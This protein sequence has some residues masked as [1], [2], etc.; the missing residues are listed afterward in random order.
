MHSLCYNVAICINYKSNFIYKLKYY[1]P[2]PPPPP[3]K[4]IVILLSTTQ[5]FLKLIY[6]VLWNYEKKCF[7]IYFSTFAELR[8]IS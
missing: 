5:Q 4:K 1:T 7:K 2:P 8:I 3:L 6:I